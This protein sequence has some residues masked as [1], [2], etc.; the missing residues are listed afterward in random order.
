MAQSENSVSITYLN[1]STD[2]I[3][4][5]DRTQLKTAF[6]LLIDSREQL[7]YFNSYVQ[8]NLGVT[9]E[10]EQSQGEMLFGPMWDTLSL[11][12]QIVK[13]MPKGEIAFSSER[14]LNEI[15]LEIILI[16]DGNGL[17]VN[18]ETNS[19]YNYLFEVEIPAISTTYTPV[20]LNADVNA[21]APAPVA[22]DTMVVNNMTNSNRANGEKLYRGL[23]VFNGSAWELDFPLK[24]TE[25]TFWMKKV[26]KAATAGLIQFTLTYQ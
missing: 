18:D 20:E 16:E 9:M 23:I 3:N 19:S 24:R 15:D 22:G 21:N 8:S 4:F 6:S 17:K 5:G 11:K 26:L 7:A 13:A 2:D 1:G 12:I 14:E 10:I 25:V